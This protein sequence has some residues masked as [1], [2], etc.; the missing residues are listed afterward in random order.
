MNSKTN[1]DEYK[2]LL[3]SA[4]KNQSEEIAYQKSDTLHSS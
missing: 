4:L 1:Y 2:Q 3:T